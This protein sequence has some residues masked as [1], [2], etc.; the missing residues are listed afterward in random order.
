MLTKSFAYRELLQDADMQREF[1]TACNLGLCATVDISHLRTRASATV[2][3]SPTAHTFPSTNN[4]QD[5]MSEDR[6]GACA[7]C[8]WIWR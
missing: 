1:S 4:S 2:R 5:E 3:P 6:V 8:R 7:P